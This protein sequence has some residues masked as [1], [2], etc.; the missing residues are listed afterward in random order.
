MEIKS[1][2]AIPEDA[3]SISSLSTELGYDMSVAKT[4]D[5]IEKISRNEQQII[6]VAI[7][8]DLI[9][10]WLHAFVTARLESG[11]FCEIGGLVVSGQHRSKGIGSLLVQNIKSWCKDK[12]VQLLKVRCNEKRIAAHK[13]YLCEGFMEVKQQK[14][15]EI[16][17]QL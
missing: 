10:G 16:N 15:F 7:I 6:Y 9:V 4:K 5:L 2:Q 3:S 1:R 11:I 17:F 14:V 12:Q 13:F 8:N